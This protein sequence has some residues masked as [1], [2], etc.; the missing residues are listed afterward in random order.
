[1]NYNRILVFFFNYSDESIVCKFDRT[2]LC[3]CGCATGGGLGTGEGTVLGIIDG[4]GSGDGNPGLGLL[5]GLNIL[6]CPGLPNGL[7]E[8]APLSVKLDLHGNPTPSVAV[9]S[10]VVSGVAISCALWS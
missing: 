4:L 10:D 3:G 9:I 5:T 2:I 1:M 6:C 8:F 7:G